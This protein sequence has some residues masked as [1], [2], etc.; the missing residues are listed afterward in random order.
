MIVLLNF[1]VGKQPTRS[2]G[3]VVNLKIPRLNS[4]T[5]KM[6]TSESGET[7][8]DDP[9]SA[10]AFRWELEQEIERLRA[11]RDEARRE[12]CEI[13]AEFADMYPKDFA[14]N[15]GW[16]CFKENTDV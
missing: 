14:M 2:N 9:A 13:S 12:V 15:R 16:D 6:T 11:E 5:W 8:S 3:C 7:M 4:Q 10:N 1:V